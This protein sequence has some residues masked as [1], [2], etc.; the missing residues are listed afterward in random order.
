MKMS[1]NTAPEFQNTHFKRKRS[2]WCVLE[3]N[4]R[5]LQ[6]FDADKNKKAWMQS[7]SFQNGWPHIAPEATR[8]GYRPPP[9]PSFGNTVHSSPGGC[10]HDEQSWNHLRV[11][12]GTWQT[13]CCTCLQ[14]A[15]I[16]VCL[17]DVQST[18]VWGRPLISTPQQTTCTTLST[19]RSS[20]SSA[21]NHGFLL[22]KTGIHAARPQSSSAHLQMHFDISNHEFLGD[23]KRTTM[24]STHVLKKHAS[25]QRPCLE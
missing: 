4:V 20:F 16:K 21:W 3:T 7:S 6:A 2:I 11:V 8:G 14:S 22:G 15:H 23:L 5:Q 24:I 12:S 1:R 10:I 17:P 25:I 13:A 19:K 18:T 9:R